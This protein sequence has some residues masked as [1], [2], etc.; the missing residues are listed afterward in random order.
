LLDEYKTLWVSFFDS[1]GTTFANF[2]TPVMY[3]FALREVQFSFDSEKLD[4][5]FALPPEHP[6]KTP[7]TDDRVSIPVPPG[8][9]FLA[10]RLTY[11]DG[12]SSVLQNFHI[13]PAEHNQL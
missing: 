2:T 7:G 3:R 11:W 1:D 10:V 6:G 5:K 12:E 9:K 8:S 13:V 4:Q